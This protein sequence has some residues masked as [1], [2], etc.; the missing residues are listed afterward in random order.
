MMIMAIGSSE[1]ECMLDDAINVFETQAH[2]YV[3][4]C[5][6]FIWL[7]IL[8]EIKHGH[9][10]LLSWGMCQCQIL[11]DMLVIHVSTCSIRK[12]IFLT[13]IQYE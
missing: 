6:A 4:L 13:P 5:F 3:L 9:S 7:R 11:H 8:V 2:S 1:V 10:I 12:S